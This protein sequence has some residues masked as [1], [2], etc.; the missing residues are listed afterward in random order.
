MFSNSNTQMEEEGISAILSQ[1]DPLVIEEMKQ[2]QA[3]N[4]KIDE[5][6]AMRNE[7]LQ[8]LDSIGLLKYMSPE[9]EKEKKEVI[10]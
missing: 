9:K 5:F 1:I 10:R 4:A 6:Q 8:K 3:T 2:M 7:F